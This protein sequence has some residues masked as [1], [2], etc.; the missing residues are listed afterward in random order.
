M[1]PAAT[2]GIVRVDREQ[3]GEGV[4]QM[5]PG[6][7]SCT[8]VVLSVLTALPGAQAPISSSERIFPSDGDIRQIIRQ[9]VDAQGKGIGMVVGVIEP[10]GARVVAYGQSGEG[11]QRPP[12]GDTTFEIG[13]MTKVFT[14]LVLADM[15]RRGEVALDDPIAK[16]LPGGV[17]IPALN[18]QPI[19]LLD[20]ATHTSGLP[21]MPDGLVSLS[22]LPTLKYSDAQLYEFLARYEPPRQT[23]TKWDYSNI[24]YSLLGK[25]L[26]ARTAMDYETLLRTRVSVP[27]ELT[28][29]GVTF[30]GLKTRLAAGHDA[31]S[32][33]T[34]PVSTVP[35]MS[36]MMPAGAVLSTANDL[37]RL[38]GVAMGYEPSPLAPAMAAMLNTR[39]PSPGGEQALGWMVEGK[40]DDQLVVHDGG[41]FGF[42]SSMVWDP[43]KRAGVVVLSNHVAGLSDV[44]RHLLRPNRPLAKPTATKRIE[45]TLDSAILDSYAG[46]YTSAAEAFVVTKEGDFLAIL[47]PADWGLPKLRLRPESLRDFFAAELPLRVTFQT[48]AD[49]QVS[50]LL[51]H[52]PRGQKAIPAK[53]AE[54]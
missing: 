19:T 10:S 20:V 27:L 4:A 15:V 49:G 39:R 6:I 13:S 45:I 1:R 22:E 50:G 17:R 5:N 24:G 53:R 46:R 21:L 8:T 11:D 28:N 30:Q 40:S 34:P 47:L 25:A 16:Y 52:P 18:G 2:D 44:P 12:D 33:P 41:T 51:I 23:G 48:N 7:L 37:L 54:R 14:A 42:A 43:K 9:R 35:I 36:V 31:S 26:A 29:T 32:Q 3:A 38:L